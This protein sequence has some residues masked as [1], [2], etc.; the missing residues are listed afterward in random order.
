[1]NI[2][3]KTKCQIKNEVRKHPKRAN[4]FAKLIFFS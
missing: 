1:M 2:T 4:L 3:T